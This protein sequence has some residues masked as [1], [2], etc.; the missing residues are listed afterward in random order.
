MQ[1]ML[2]YYVDAYPNYPE[3]LEH[4]KHWE[5]AQIVVGLDRLGALSPGGMVISVGAGHEEPIFDLT[6]R[7][8]W[9]FATDIYGSGNFRD[10][11]ADGAMLVD[12]DRFA[13]SPYRRGRLVVQHMSALDLR[14]EDDTFDAAMSAS[15][16][17]H[18]GGVDGAGHALK[19]MARVVRPGG[20]VA[21]TTECIINGAPHWSDPELQLFTPDEI[22]TLATSVDSL[23]PVEPLD[24]D[25]SPLADVPA[26]ALEK[27][28]ADAARHHIEYPHIVLELNGRR[29]TSVSL[30]LRKR[31][32]V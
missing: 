1:R 23:E 27:A 25:P 20:I 12:P 32:R 22:Q 15:S 28:L 13:R 26:I 19:E 17:E 14:H 9:V 4:R 5:F 3:G 16:I 6:N 11:E 29:W 2:P 7:V 18:F 31:R 21:I 30:F 8:R 24:L 10:L